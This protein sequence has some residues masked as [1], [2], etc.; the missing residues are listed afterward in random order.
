MS[1][2]EMIAELNATC[3]RMLAAGVDSNKVDDFKMVL[4]LELDRKFRDA[5]LDII[6]AELAKQ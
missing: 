2:K 5:V 4:M 6:E 3:D 1:N